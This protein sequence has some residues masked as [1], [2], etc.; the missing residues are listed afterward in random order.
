MMRTIINLRNKIKLK[1]IKKEEAIDLLQ[2]TEA[3]HIGY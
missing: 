3:Q 2:E 1:L